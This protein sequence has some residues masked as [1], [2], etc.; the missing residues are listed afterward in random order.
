[1]QPITLL[2]I[3]TLPQHHKSN[4]VWKTLPKYINVFVVKAIELPKELKTFKKLHNK[5]VKCIL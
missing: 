5:E 3:Q 2:V 4:K 1:M